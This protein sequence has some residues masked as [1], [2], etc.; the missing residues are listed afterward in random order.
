MA[1][2]VIAGEGGVEDEAIAVEG[3]RAVRRGLQQGFE[4]RHAAVV[5]VG[6]GEPERGERGDAVAIGGSD[7]EG[8][9]GDEGDEADLFLVEAAALAVA[10]DEDAV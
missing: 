2:V 5:Q 10:V 1:A 4:G 9:A 7:A 8:V 3:G 6:G